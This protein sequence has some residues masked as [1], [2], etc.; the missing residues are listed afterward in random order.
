MPGFKNVSVND[1]L[2]TS[3]SSAC[4]ISSLFTILWTLYCTKEMLWF[5]LNEEKISVDIFEEIEELLEEDTDW[6]PGLGWMSP[7][8]SSSRKNHVTTLSTSS[9]IMHCM[10]NLAFLFAAVPGS[11]RLHRQKRLT[12]LVYEAFA[13]NHENNEYVCAIRGSKAIKNSKCRLKLK[14][15]MR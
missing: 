8:H 13:F 14:A 12:P 9:N 10:V 11:T 3:K 1:K 5:R 7:A 15:Y 2:S 4:K 6:G